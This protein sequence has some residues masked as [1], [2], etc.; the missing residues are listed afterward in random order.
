MQKI[1]NEQGETVKA[2]CVI[3]NETGELLVVTPKDRENWGLPKGHA[4]AGESAEEVAARETYEETGYTVQIIRQLEDL[5][6]KHPKRNE[7][8]RVH[9]F[10]AE[11]VAQT[12][13][14]EEHY[15]WVN[16]NEAKKLLYPNILEYITNIAVR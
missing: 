1:K 10:L 7:H 3:F 16:M 13:K 5:V 11:A 15:K 9:L 12:G 4:E 8:I 2:G 6:Y 14:P